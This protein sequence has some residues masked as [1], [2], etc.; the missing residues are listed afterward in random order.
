M[1][2][3]TWCLCSGQHSLR[4][5]HA[6]GFFAAALVLQWS[7]LHRMRRAPDAQTVQETCIEALHLGP[8]L[9]TRT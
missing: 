7:R 8:P 5:P 9:G 3:C 1:Q 6:H 2:N 4:W